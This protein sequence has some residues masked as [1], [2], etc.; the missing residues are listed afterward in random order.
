MKKKPVVIIVLFLLA[1]IF[2]RC[3]EGL[4]NSK[5]LSNSAA[6][7]VSNT[8]TATSNLATA[9]TVSSSSEYTDGTGTVHIKYFWA[10]TGPGQHNTLTVPVDPNYVLVGGS[11]IAF[12]GSGVGALLS[13]SRPDFAN[14]A[15]VGSSQDHKTADAHYLWVVATGLRIDGLTPA[16][17]RTYISV[18]SSTSGSAQHPSASSTIPNGYMLLGGGAKVNQDNG[19]GNMLVTSRPLVSST[20]WNGWYAESA[21]QIDPDLAT[22]TVYSIGIQ[23]SIP[24]LFRQLSIGQYTNGPVSTI[25]SGPYYLDQ[26]QLG[27]NNGFGLLFTCPGAYSTHSGSAGRLL[28]GIVVGPHVFLSNAGNGSS[29]YLA[30]TANTPGWFGMT[31]DHIYPDPGTITTYV[32]G[33]GG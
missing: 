12:Y 9:I 31:K 25:G 24:G 11:A 32:V 10:S 20:P 29:S 30:M 27:A 6:T 1:F 2:S 5:S 22:I 18:T 19:M 17:L 13:E 15:W 21:D 26:T 33:L 8:I 28:V 7:I 16:Q 23:R 4:E 3:M 14:N